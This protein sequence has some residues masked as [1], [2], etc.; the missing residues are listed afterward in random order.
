MPLYRSGIKH[1][2]LGGARQ[3][4]STPVNADPLGGMQT[5]LYYLGL[6]CLFTHELDA[7]SHSEWRLLFV[8]LGGPA[9]PAGMGIDITLEEL[10]TEWRLMADL[11]ALAIQ[12][13][14]VRFGS[15]R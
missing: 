14:R 10:T 3:R 12:M 7:V 1:F 15:V 11:Y 5:A 2:W 6:S 13:D 8:L 4:Y 9:D